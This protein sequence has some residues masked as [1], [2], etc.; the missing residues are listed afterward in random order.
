MPRLT[1]AVAYLRVSSKGQEDGHGFDRQE[2]AI[3][4]YAKR[5][6][7]VQQVYQEAFSGTEADRP[8]FAQMVSDLLSNG[9]RTVLVESLDRLARELV[10]QTQLLGMLRARGI[11]LVSAATGQDV[12]E[13]LD[14]DPMMKAL[15][16]IQ[17]VFAELDK[18]LLVNKLRKAR[19][20]KKATTGR[21]EG[22]KPYGA[23]PGEQ[24]TL[25]KIFRLRQAKHLSYREIV[26]RLNKSGVRT[27]YGKR[28]NPGTIKRVIDRGRKWPSGAGG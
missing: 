27:R 9:C 16:Q 28:W 2:R 25:K 11:S 19:E 14:E 18:G 7:R 6:F 1:P 20:A 10:V 4:T 5:R 22:R 12:T 15:V 17:G 26:Q 3:R 24:G 13:A 8:V 21:C 23:K